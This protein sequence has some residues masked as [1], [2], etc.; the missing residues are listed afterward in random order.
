LNVPTTAQ[1]AK[2]HYV[3]VSERVDDDVLTDGKAAQTRAQI[4]VAAASQVRIIGKK[5]ESLCNRIDQTVRGLGAALTD[6]T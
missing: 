5:Q 6:A 4:V 1:H 2:N 3:L